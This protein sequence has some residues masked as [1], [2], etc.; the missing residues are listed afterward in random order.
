MNEH[1]FLVSAHPM[2]SGDRF[3]RGTKRVLVTG[4]AGFIGFHLARTLMRSKNNT[5]YT[6]DNFNDYYDTQLKMVRYD[7]YFFP[8]LK[9]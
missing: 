3:P 7:P 8:R 5:V 2:P 4:G 9:C 6:I 1:P